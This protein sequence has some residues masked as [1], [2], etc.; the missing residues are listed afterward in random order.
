VFFG[1]LAWL[2]KNSKTLIGISREHPTL[3]RL[4]IVLQV[5][6]SLDNVRISCERI[7]PQERKGLSNHYDRLSQLL[8]FGLL[9][10]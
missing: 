1:L 7:L 6:I 8:N 2:K 4:R 5:Q 3:F 10:Q 9:K